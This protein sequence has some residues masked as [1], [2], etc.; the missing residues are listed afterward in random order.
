MQ[1]YEHAKHVSTQARQ[2][3]NLAGS[4]LAE[5]FLVLDSFCILWF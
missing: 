5:I 4:C 1:A 2:A 3:C